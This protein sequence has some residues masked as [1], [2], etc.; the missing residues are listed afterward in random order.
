MTP[1]G[2]QCF[3]DPQ[4]NLQV[5]AGVVMQAE[6]GVTLTVGGGGAIAEHLPDPSAGR[7]TAALQPAG[8]RFVGG[9]GRNFT[10][11]GMAG[12]AAPNGWWVPT[13]AGRF[14]HG[15]FTLTVTAP[16]AATI[17]DASDVVAI[18]STGTAAPAGNYVSTNYGAATYNSAAAFTLVLAAEIT[19]GGTLPSLLISMSAGTAQ[20]G[21]YNATSIG[22]YTSAVDANWTLVV[23]PSGSAQL[24]H[25]TTVMATRAV[26]DGD[27]PSG[28]FVAVAAGF[29][30]HPLPPAPLVQGVPAATNPFGILTVTYSWP[31]TPDLDDRTTFLDATVGFPGPYT[32]AYL[33]HTGDNTSAAGSETV[34]V[35]L[36]AAWTAGAIATHADILCCADWYPV[37]SS[38]LATLSL[39]YTIG[40][41]TETLSISPGS[42]RPSTTPVANL[43]V[44]AD[45]TI[46]HAGAVW[47]GYSQVIP[48]LPRAGFAYL[49][50]VKV[51]GV[52]TAVN[53]P[54]FKTALPSAFGETS[55]LPLAK[56][57]G[58]KLTQL[59]TGALVVAGPAAIIYSTGLAWVSLT[60]AA[61]DALTS[62]SA[63]TVYD[64]TDAP[65]SP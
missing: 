31:A 39:S 44:L 65:W 21:I 9:S 19:G 43:R 6:T 37:G 40:A 11:T 15:I 56:C 2:F 28:P 24:R 8:T 1:P 50:V 41:L 55:Y 62:P 14:V 52:L 59:H 16:G 46:T 49:E 42:A 20:G 38:G 36:A 25:L 60:Q 7:F 22:N 5:T 10:A 13:I 18:L 54:F 64:I 29:F 4:G 53:G 35:D 23:D 57:D 48:R 26:G 30:Y 27:D 51:S 3:Y 45:G 32:A 34:T 58:S 63:T 33:T 12:G 17:S 47:T 61:Y